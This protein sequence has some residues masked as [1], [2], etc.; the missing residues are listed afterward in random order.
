M[1]RWVC[2]EDAEKAKILIPKVTYVWN[3]YLQMYV[4]IYYLV[5]V[6]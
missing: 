1:E 4:E 6:D 3:Y 5:E 2:P